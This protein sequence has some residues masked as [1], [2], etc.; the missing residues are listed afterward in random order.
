ME[1]ILDCKWSWMAKSYLWTLGQAKISYFCAKFFKDSHVHSIN[2]R[3]ISLGC[4]SPSNDPLF[5]EAISSLSSW[6]SFSSFS[7]SSGSNWGPVCTSSS[8]PVGRWRPWLCDRMGMSE[9]TCVCVCVCVCVCTCIMHVRSVSIPEPFY[10]GTKV[11]SMFL[12]SDLLRW[13]RL[14]MWFVS[15]VDQSHSPELHSGV[16][17]VTLAVEE[18]RTN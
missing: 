12:H 15:W 14:W 6:I 1:R 2:L 7:F 11:N 4:W 17:A 3:S 10:Q 5:M 9:C 18:D 13:T 8:S 16:S